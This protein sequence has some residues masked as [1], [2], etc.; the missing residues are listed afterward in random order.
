MTE[1]G[2]YLL[3]TNVVSESGKLRTQPAIQNFLANIP[4]DRL[5]L[6]VLTVGA[7]FKGLALRR[8]QNP[9]MGER[10]QLWVRRMEL[11]FRGQF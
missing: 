11:A 8:R 10:P 1:T 3:D 4:S 7:I 9:D 6:S 5:F 2:R